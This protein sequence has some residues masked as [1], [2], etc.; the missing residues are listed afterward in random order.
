MGRMLPTPIA[1]LLLSHLFSFTSAQSSSSGSTPSGTATSSSAAT[2]W[3][4]SV[5]EGSNV[6]KPSAIQ[7]NIG[8]IIQFDFYPANHSVARAE[9][10]YP[11]IPYE[12][13]GIGKVGF[14]SGFHPVDVILNSP[15]TWSIRVNDSLPIFY[16]CTAPGACI[17]DQMVGVINPVRNL[18]QL[19]S[20]H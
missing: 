20:K 2:T 14:F 4:I 3:T 6:F 16:Y 10:L 5:G 7:A 18:A 9:Y 19:F 17:S 12:D 1:L 15:P 13:T 11:C 8:D